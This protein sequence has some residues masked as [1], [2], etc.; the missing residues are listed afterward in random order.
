M[1]AE[2]L[3]DLESPAARVRRILTNEP[4]DAASLIDM[5]LDEYP[6]VEAV[7]ETRGEQRKAARLWRQRCRR[8]R[9]SAKRKGDDGCKHIWST[10]SVCR[11]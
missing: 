8:R 6:Q 2:T 11:S 7:A 1:T 10:C 5:T 4:D 3:D 9:R